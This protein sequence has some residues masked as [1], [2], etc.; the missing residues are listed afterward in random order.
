MS[1]EKR[2]VQWSITLL[3]FFWSHYSYSELCAVQG[4]KRRGETVRMSLP[5]QLERT[6]QFGSWWLHRV[7]LLLYL[8]KIF[9]QGNKNTLFLV[10]VYSVLF[11][12]FKAMNL[13]LNK[14]V[15]YIQLPGNGIW[16]F[17]IPQR[18]YTEFWHGLALVVNIT[19]CKEQRQL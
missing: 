3:I 9:R 12:I 1:I 11:N 4:G 13:F 6:P 8:I 5:S 7:H 2:Q 19:K 17:S 14:Y 10:M 15:A 16:L 18:F